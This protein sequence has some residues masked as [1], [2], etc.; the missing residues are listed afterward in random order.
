MATQHVIGSSNPANHL[1]STGSHSS[2][3]SNIVG[4]HYKVGKKIGEGS[5][6]VIFEGT[7]TV[8]TGGICRA[9]SRDQPAQLTDGSHQVCECDGRRCSSATCAHTQEPRKSDAPQLRDE[10]RSYKILSGC[11]ELDQ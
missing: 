6:G 7:F 3:S 9:D 4:V 10:Y 2:S 8:G 5:F 11:C 1:S